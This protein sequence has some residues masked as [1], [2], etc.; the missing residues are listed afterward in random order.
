M[1]RIIKTSL[2]SLGLAF[3]EAHVSIAGPIAQPTDASDKTTDAKK[4]ASADTTIPASSNK[5]EIRQKR[6]EERTR[7]LLE[8]S[9][10]SLKDLE[11]K[12]ATASDII[13]K[14]ANLA[15]AHAKLELEAAKDV[16][17]SES[18]A[19]HARRCK[20]YLFRAKDVL[21]GKDVIAKEKSE[22]KKN[23]E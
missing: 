18:I 17:F 8:T 21:E 4:E 6:K 1:N 20:Q 12:V 5:Q 14:K 22:P 23:Q 9:E 16:D 19:F 10:A 3:G 2:L 11:I 13:K 15:L 7:K